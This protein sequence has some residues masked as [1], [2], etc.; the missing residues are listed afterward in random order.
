M[1]R[2]AF[3]GL[4]FRESL[5]LAQ[6]LRYYFEPEEKTKLKAKAADKIAEALE[7][8]LD[9]CPYDAATSRAIA[10]ERLKEYRKY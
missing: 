3:E 4:S 2:S 10:R 9:P 8:F 1:A 7:W 5:T 6:K